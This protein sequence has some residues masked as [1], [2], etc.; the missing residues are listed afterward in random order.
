MAHVGG[1]AQIAQ[2]FDSIYTELTL[3]QRQLI[4]AMREGREDPQLA[5][6]ARILIAVYEA[7][8]YGE[9]V[10]R[11]GRLELE[12]EA[13]R[14]R[15]LQ[16]PLDVELLEAGLRAQR[17]RHAFPL[18]S[19]ALELARQADTIELFSGHSIAKWLSLPYGVSRALA[20]KLAAHLHLNPDHSPPELSADELQ[21][22]IDGL[23]EAA[24]SLPESVQPQHRRIRGRHDGRDA[25]SVVL[26]AWLDGV[27]RSELYPAVTEARSRPGWP[28]HALD[29]AGQLSRCSLEHLAVRHLPA[30][31]PILQLETTDDRLKAMRTLRREWWASGEDRLADLAHALDLLIEAV[32]AL[33]KARRLVELPE[34]QWGS[35]SPLAEARRCARRCGNFIS[36]WDPEPITEHL[37]RLPHDDFS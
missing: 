20:D 37:H 9:T 6:R 4:A 22:L 19:D 31:E 36:F 3:L 32:G 33:E 15:V 27:G 30:L 26:D 25:G 7:A 12:A 14:A 1:I 28:T 2:R 21:R 18:L 17:R 29:V 11:P 5:E 13:I 34:S 35:S 16:H 10:G 23:R 8:R 24:V